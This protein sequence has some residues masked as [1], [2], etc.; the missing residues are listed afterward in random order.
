MTPSF[1]TVL[2]DAAHVNDLRIESAPVGH[3]IN[4]V[5]HLDPKYGGLSTVVPELASVV[6]SLREHS[7]GIAAFCA[8]DECYVPSTFSSDTVSYWPLSRG[9]W[10]RDSDLRRR[11]RNEISSADG[12]HIH[13]LW[14]QSTAIAGQM[15]RSLRKPYILSA[16]GMLESWALAN[17]RVKKLIYS[18]LIERTN[19]EGAR[20][21]H[22]LTHA[23]A[24]D[25]RRFGSKCPIAIIPN[26]VN[27]PDAVSHDIFY[28]QFPALKG[29]NIILFLG[30]LHLKKGLIPLVQAWATLTQRWPEA[31]LVLAGPDCEGTQANLEK[32]LVELE[33]TDRVTF[34][35]MLKG[36]AKWSAFA[37]AQCFVLPSFS[38]GLSVSVLE[39]MGTGL[40]VIVTE[41]CNIPEVT[42]YETGWCIQPNVTHLTSALNE[43]LHHSS[44]INKQIGARGR[45]LVLARYNWS[46]VGTQM[47]E[48]YHWVQGGPQPSTFDLVMK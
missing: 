10:L 21:L 17:K 25:Y 4:V 23:E 39:A 28:S 31:H 5:S 35:G 15:A 40:P 13:G 9:T 12:V 1:N 18:A 7:T 34:T 36:E 3:W 19:V 29:K 8:P 42:Q 22:A 2:V 32:I 24:E 14:E 20:C 30:R 6:T 45:R 46:F 38:E 27:I 41:Q 48:L 26:G 11:F 37:A 16:H 43:F 33:I 47:S 44:V